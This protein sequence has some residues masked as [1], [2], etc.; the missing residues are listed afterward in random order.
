MNEA[1][2][3]LVLAL[4]I[5]AA[6]TAV[7]FVARPLTPIDE[8]RYISVAWEM[9]LRGDWL[10]PFKNGEP[11]SHKPPLLMWIY[12][13][14]WL[15]FGVSEWWARLVSPLFA[16][17]SGVLT[18]TLAR[19]LWPEWPESDGLGERA[20]LILASCAL[21]IFSATTA[22]FDVM[23]AC[24][25]LLGMHGMVSAAEG[26]AGRGFALLGLAIGLGVLAKGPVILLH[27]LPVA[28]LAP[29]WS[30]GLAWK[31]WSLGVLAA[32]L[33]GATIAL[34]WAI[35]AGIAG[36]EEYRHAIF[37]GQTA[38]RMVQS[39][40]HQRPF[41]WYL[42]LLPLL[43]F[44]WALW[45]AL[46]RGLRELAQQGLDRG[47]RL[48]LAWSLPVLLAFS[49]ISGKQVHYLVPF[50]PALALL[51]ARALVTG[52]EGSVAL[53]SLLAAGL[54]AALLLF[55][56]GDL[57]HARK[58]FPE[59]PLPVPAWMLIVAA[60]AVWLW[61]R[62]PRTPV[63]MPALIGA[64][65]VGFFQLSMRDSFHSDYDTRP[66]AAAVAAAQARGCVIA[67]DGVYHDQFHFAGRL[68][69]PFMAF[70]DE[71]EMAKWL[72]RNP[73]ACALIYVRHAASLH[74]YRVLFSHGYLGGAAALMEASEAAAVLRETNPD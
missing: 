44:P 14:G 26:R 48:C 60:L 56:H 4:V 49:L 2:R 67:N 27:T 58:L 57:S 13:I 47:S 37:W 52:K 66:L 64:F 54:G 69:Q 25:T 5:L 21:W 23:L 6:L 40:A 36:G 68:R 17:A 31:R 39:F 30:P 9:W 38:N 12:Q 3:Q 33:L 71:R 34:V 46:W 45:P 41:W 35:P 19:R 73:Q 28:V 16:V 18:L 10:V 63:L 8:T 51:A 62:R 55:A 22:M 42:P 43:F 29:W 65:V 53:P 11:Y 7:A 24:F 74:G 32:V 70:E 15:V 1:R 72:D 61:P 20:V 59:L 50:V